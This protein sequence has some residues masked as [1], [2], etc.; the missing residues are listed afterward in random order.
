MPRSRPIPSVSYVEIDLNDIDWQDM[1]T[2]Y[3]PV[4]V[5]YLGPYRLCSDGRRW[6]VSLKGTFVE[7]GWGEDNGEAGAVSWL[8]AHFRLPA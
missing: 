1:V 7:L 3:G 2:D 4:R 8:R 5:A 6:T